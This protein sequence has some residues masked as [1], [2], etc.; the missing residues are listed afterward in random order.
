MASQLTAENAPGVPHPASDVG[1]LDHATFSNI[2]EQHKNLYQDSLGPW[3]KM[4]EE[5]IELQLLPDF[6]DS[7]GVYVEFNIAEKLAGSFEEQTQALQSAVGRP[8]MTANE[9]RARMNL[10]SINGDANELVTPLNVLTGGQASPRDSAPDET[11][12]EKSRQVI[13]KADDVDIDARRPQARRQHERKWEETMVRTF[14]RQQ[15]AILG[16]IPAEKGRKQAITV[17]E[18]WDVMR[19]NKELTEDLYALN[20][21]TASEWAEYVAK[22]AGGEFDQARVLAWLQENARI[23]A[24]EI[25]AATREQ[26]ADALTQDE[27]RA[28]AKRVFEVAIG[29]RAR[30]IAVSK[31]TTARFGRVGARGSAGSDERLVVNST[32]RGG[33]RR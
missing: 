22:Q 25:N 20:V 13:T 33:A 10:P 17:G 3:L 4:I 11:A 29:A 28:V 12:P 21:F 18:L 14:R 31:V 32:T 23:A 24:E 27:P 9:A 8:W 2:K 6:D 30:A 16:K 1:I 5:D 7:D 19:W 15:D 26:L